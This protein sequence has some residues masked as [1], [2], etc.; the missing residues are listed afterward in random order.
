MF[1]INNSYIFYN[2]IFIF[3]Y[4]KKSITCTFFIFKKN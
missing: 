1:I 2:C 4:S 3:Y